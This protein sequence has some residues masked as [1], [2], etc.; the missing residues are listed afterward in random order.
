LRVVRFG[1]PI[2]RSSER[3]SGYRKRAVNINPK[4]YLH[5][6]PFN[7]I[8]RENARSGLTA[9]LCPDS[10]KP[11]VMLVALGKLCS[12]DAKIAGQ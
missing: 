6:K 5:N 12:C 2:N 11:S 1:G 4:W 8:A 9:A 10:M 3:V 7:P